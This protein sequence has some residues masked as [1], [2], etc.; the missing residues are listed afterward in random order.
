MFSAVFT[1]LYF[2]YRIVV[3]YIYKPRR[4]VLPVTD[5]ADELD[6]PCIIEVNAE[7]TTQQPIQY[8]TINIVPH[9]KVG[10]EEDNTEKVSAICN[11]KLIDSVDVQSMTVAII[12]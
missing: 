10:E 7:Y 11:A 6:E 12:V 9:D 5:Y 3:K 2:I 1:I 4:M 8:A